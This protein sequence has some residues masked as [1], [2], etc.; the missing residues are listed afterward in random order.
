VSVCP[1]MWLDL[2]VVQSF[3]EK[4]DGNDDVDGIYGINFVIQ[5]HIQDKRFC[6]SGSEIDEICNGIDGIAPFKKGE[7]LY[8]G[9]LQ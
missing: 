8:F 6:D 5:W 9:V 1:S 3:K 4:L 2:R 7:M